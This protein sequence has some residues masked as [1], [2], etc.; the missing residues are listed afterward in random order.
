MADFATEAGGLE[1]RAVCGGHA[2]ATNPIKL[3]PSPRRHIAGL[4]L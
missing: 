1:A 4:V 2:L 3:N